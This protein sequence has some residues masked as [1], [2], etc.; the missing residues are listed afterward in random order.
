[1]TRRLTLAMFAAL[2]LAAVP[3]LAHPGHNH[4]ILGTVTMAAADHVMVKGKDGKDVTVHITKETKIL[5]EK[6]AA[7][8]EDIQN[9]MRI[10]VTAV[11][12]TVNKVERLRAKTIEIGPAPTAK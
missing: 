7:K 11:T 9:G 10:V 8:V 4:K 5:K 12:E 3:A 1:M 2:A 6:R